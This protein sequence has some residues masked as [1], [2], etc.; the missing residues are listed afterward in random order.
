[1]GHL[2]R[3]T[4]T[5][6]LVMFVILGT[7]GIGTAYAGILPLITLA[8]DVQ[9]DG[10]LN[11]D[12]PITGVDYQYSSPQ[13]RFLTINPV[14]FA[15]IV[16]SIGNSLNFGAY[17]LSHIGGTGATAVARFPVTGL[18]DG[19]KLQSLTCSFLE[20]DS[21]QDALFRCKLMRHQVLPFGGTVI[22]SIEHQTSGSSPIFQTFTDTDFVGPASLGIVDTQN[23]SY[24]LEI[25]IDPN[26]LSLNCAPIRCF[27]GHIQIAY[28]VDS[29][30]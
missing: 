25:N 9:V 14:A 27:F 21:N 4:K 15:A 24:Y 26:P 1:M 3:F 30:D 23:D 2:G 8:G 19:A 28:T 13:T 18:P 16:N 22:Y 6:Y 7:A 10:S 12:G 17:E 29:V 20:Q 5:P 11:A